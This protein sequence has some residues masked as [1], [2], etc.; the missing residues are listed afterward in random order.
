M[1]N[2]ELKANEVA[3]TTRVVDGRS[4]FEAAARGWSSG[5]CNSSAEALERLTA[6][7][8]GDEVSEAAPGMASRA[9]MEA[10]TALFAGRLR[11]RGVDYTAEPGELHSDAWIRASRQILQTKAYKE[12]EFRGATLRSV[13]ARKGSAAD[14]YRALITDDVAARYRATCDYLAQVAFDHGRIGF[15]HVATAAG[16]GVNWAQA[17]IEHI[18]EMVAEDVDGPD[19]LELIDA[20]D[21]SAPDGGGLRGVEIPAE[22]GQ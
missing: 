12:P 11:I 4:Y 1:S 20:T 10:A 13:K 15:H 2:T 19:L 17:R 18:V 7:H 5:P 8:R 3:L 14:Q 6:Y 9:E 16:N 21:V 22:D